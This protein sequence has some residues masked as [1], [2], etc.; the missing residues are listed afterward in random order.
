MRNVL[1]TF[2]LIGLG[3]ASSAIPPARNAQLRAV[4][5]KRPNIVI[6]GAYLG[7]VEVCAGPSGTGITED[8]YERVGTAK[9]SNP[10][11]GDEVWIFPITCHSTWI[12]STRV[13]VK[14]FD[15]SGNY[16]GT[17]SLPYSGVT[18]VAT[19]LCACNSFPDRCR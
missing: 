10:A 11:G 17:K 6:R 15:A 1:A 14:A 4:K 8:E 18:D 16:V 9:R 2:L 3:T 5:I 19:A 13:F 12:V 7:G